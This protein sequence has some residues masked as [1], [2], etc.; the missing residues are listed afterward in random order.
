[1][2]KRKRSKENRLGEDKELREEEMKIKIDKFVKEVSQFFKQKIAEEKARESGFVERTSKLTGHL[3]LTVFTFGMSLYGVPT[4]NQL[5]GLLST[6]ELELD[7]KREGLHQRITEKAVKFFEEMLS[8]VIKLEV[9]NDVGVKILEG[10][11]RIILFDSTSFQLPETLTEYFKG[12][13]GDASPSA[14]KILFGYDLKGAKFFYLL[15]N[16]TDADH[17]LK[18]GIIEE[19]KENDLEISDLGFFGVETFAEIAQKEAFYLSRLKSDATLYQKNEAGEL[20]VFDLPELVKKMKDEQMEIKVYLKKNKT[21]IETR[22]VI[23]KVPSQVKAERLRKLYQRNQKKG[24]QTKKRTKIL[25]A[26]NLHITNAPAQFLPANRV[27]Q[28]Y[29]I[30][31]QIELIFKSW[32]SNFSLDKVT[33][34]RPQR[35]KC[36]IYAKL[37]FI[38]ISSKLI[39]VAS[40]LA[41]NTLNREVSAFQAAKHILVIGHEWLKNILLQPETVQPLLLNAITFIVSHC[42][43]PKS[44][45]RLYPLQIVAAI[46]MEGLT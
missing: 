10:F 40:A 13:G 20:E 30:R 37:L 19:I 8:L 31:W 38:F 45:K 34:K 6:L 36:M 43:K 18:S 17:L 22:L 2:A 32:K 15:L 44:K 33:G 3:F 26:V 27:R 29:T 4:L 5:V 42:L 25:Q 39:S 23:E 12:S 41:W 24:H 21:I 9:P 7:I 14:I 11:K 1:M 35:I 46:D 28:F 16:G